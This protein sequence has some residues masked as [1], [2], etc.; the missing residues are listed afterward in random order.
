MAK[1]KTFHD[2]FLDEIKDAYD[3]ER[4]LVKALPRMIRAATSDELQE[5]LEAHLEETRGHVERLEQAFESLDEKPRGKH[6]EGM[7]GILEEGKGALEEDFDEV[8]TDACIIAGS[9]R[10]E[11]YEIAAYGTLVAWAKAMGH[12]EAMQLFEETLA[13]EKA[14]DEKLTAISEAINA[15]A[16]GAA[17]MEGDAD[18]EGEEE[19]GDEED[20]AAVKATAPARAPAKKAASGGRRR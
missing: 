10:V 11:H 20:E 16:A 1:T 7:A 9:Q 2:A 14:A 17:N 5:A 13:E 3:A 6:C 12:D 15:E 4:Q 19:E 18:E 8:T